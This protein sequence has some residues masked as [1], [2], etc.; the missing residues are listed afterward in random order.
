MADLNDT[1]VETPAVESPRG[2]LVE[3]LVDL[4]ERH[5]QARLVAVTDPLTGAEAPIV[6]TRD[7]EGNQTVEELDV[8]VFNDYLP[9]P[10]DRRGI[11]RMTSLVSFIDHANRF[12]DDASAVFA[13]DDRDKPSLTAVLDYSPGGAIS[14]AGDGTP[15]NFPRHGRHR[16]TYAFPFSDEWQAWTGKNAE[17]MTVPQFAAFL[18]DRIGD[19]AAP[20]EFPIPAYA[21]KYIERI[22]GQDRIAS[23]TDLV[24]LSRG[25]KINENAAVAETHNLS[26][27]E[28]EVLFST[29]HT[30][31]RDSTG[32]PLRI[33]TS[34][35][36]GIPV[37]RNDGYYAVV[38]RLRYRTKPVLNFSFELYRV[39]LVFDHAFDTAVAKVEEGTSLPVFRGSP[40][41]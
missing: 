34:F 7:G 13:C 33:P 35:L 10:R 9:N 41:A 17:A 40:E 28:G 21:E 38:A 36:I 16:T 8:S 26:S 5:S 32:A 12:K 1:A 19:V 6:L 4:V 20:G 25:L 3:Q 27:G 22:G 14:T 31:A 15:V 2:D 18:E 24:I 23:P 39:D 30:D 37:F 11:A 29:E